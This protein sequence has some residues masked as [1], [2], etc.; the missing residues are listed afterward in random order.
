MK[1]VVITGGTG[2]IG[3]ALCAELTDAGYEVVVLS[4]TPERYPDLPA[5]VLAWPRDCAAALAGAAAVV[6]LAGENIAARLRWTAAVKARILDSRLAAGRILAAAVAALDRPPPVLVQASAIGW[7]GDRGDET[8]DESSP[9]GNGF[10]AD[11]ARQWEL[12][13]EPFAEQGLRTVRIRTGLV[14][15]P[16]AGI[17]PR[18]ARP[19][20]FG[21]GGYLGSGRQW[22][23]WIHL[24]DEVR[25]IRFL[26]EQPTLSGVFN[27]TA[28]QPL[29]ARAFARQLGAVLHRPALLPVPA[30]VVR[31]LLGEM[32]RE[33]LLGSQRVIPRR[34]QDAG[35]RFAFAQLRPALENLL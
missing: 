27:L 28:P 20:R 15:G 18:L 22:M 1:R 9:S 14:L 23:S 4:R 13:V 7:Y 30:P 10:L 3:Q 17:L 16:Q 6:N 31:A 12:L 11:V 8:L 2:C 25:A 19:F 34:L 33:L 32:G 35:F 21:A 24:H 29:M 5:R 26:I